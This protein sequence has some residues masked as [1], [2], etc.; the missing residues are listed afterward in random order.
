MPQAA[1]HLP[2]VVKGQYTAHA[3]IG[4]YGNDGFNIS[5]YPDNGVVGGNGTKGNPYMIEG[6]AISSPC[7]GV[8]IQQTD[9][10][11][12]IRNSLIDVET[13]YTDCMGLS[14]V[15][16]FQNVTNGRVENNSLSGRATVPYVSS[17]NIPIIEGS[18]KN[19]ISYNNVNIDGAFLVL[20]AGNN[21]HHNNFWY[22]QVGVSGGNVW[23]TSTEGNYWSNFD[24]PSEGCYDNDSNGICDTPYIINGWMKDFFPLTH[25]VPVVP[26]FS[27]DGL[28]IFAILVITISAVALR[29]KRARRPEISKR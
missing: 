17:V 23:N 26:Q 3:P 16:L 21:I 20:Q 27:T 10:Y 1:P 8:W 22:T 9:A 11:F 5:K 18:T 19:I 15:I 14:D 13:N 24:E 6:W 12:V 2:P 29:N 28:V 25:P 4:M 7:V